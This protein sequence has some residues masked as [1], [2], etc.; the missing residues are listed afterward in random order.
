[1]GSHKMPAAGAGTAGLS[2]N[3]IGDDCGYLE[4]IIRD[5]ISVNLT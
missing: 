5:N 1:M 3:Y 4:A 2:Q